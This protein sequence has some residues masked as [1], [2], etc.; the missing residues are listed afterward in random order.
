MPWLYGCAALISYIL[1][2][3]RD[4]TFDT[5]CSTT[6][7]NFLNTKIDFKLYLTQENTKRLNIGSKYEI[8][9]HFIIT[10]NKIY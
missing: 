1:A 8:F 9:S 5:L 4:L 7:S 10:R 2:V 3:R 6:G